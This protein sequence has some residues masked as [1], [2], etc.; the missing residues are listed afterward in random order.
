[1]KRIALTLAVSSLVLA[2]VASAGEQLTSAQMDGITAGSNLAA[3]ALATAFGNVTYATTYSSTANTV[4]GEVALPEGGKVQQILG[5]AI[6]MS[7]SGADGQSAAL[8]EAGGAVIGD[9]VADSESYT[10][11]LADSITPA[12]GAIAWNNSAASSLIRGWS[13]QSASNSA[14]SSVLVLH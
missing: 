13:A 10:T 5:I 4:T 1:M 12:S 6:A 14:V 11:T 7:S 2:G 3:T 8:A 9:N